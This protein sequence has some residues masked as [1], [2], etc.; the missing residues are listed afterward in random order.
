MNDN[1]IAQIT[2]V[3]FNKRKAPGKDETIPVVNV[4]ELIKRGTSHVRLGDKIYLIICTEYK[5]K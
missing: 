5:K 3:F 1:W 2:D 4:Q